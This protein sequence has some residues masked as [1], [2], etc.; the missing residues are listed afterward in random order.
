MAGIFK[1]GLCRNAGEKA[2]HQEINTRRL[3]AQPC[4]RETG[5]YKHGCPVSTFHYDGYDQ[6]CDPERGDPADGGSLFARGSTAAWQLK[7][8]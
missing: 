7:I 8:A 4:P 2:V 1:A 3:Q 5:L 6:S